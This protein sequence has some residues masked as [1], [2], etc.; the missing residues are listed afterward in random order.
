MPMLLM[1][2]I[3][4]M[5]CTNAPCLSTSTFFK[6][7]KDM[8]GSFVDDCLHIHVFDIRRTSSK[9][10]QIAYGTNKFSCKILQLCYRVACGTTLDGHWTPINIYFF[11]MWNKPKMNYLQWFNCLCDKIYASSVT[12]YISFGLPAQIFLLRLMGFWPM[13]NCY[14]GRRLSSESAG[15]TH[16][17]YASQLIDRNKK[18]KRAMRILVERSMRPMIIDAGGLFELS[19]PAFVKVIFDRN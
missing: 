11:C 14:F 9:A 6:S 3:G 5:H 17:I 1:Y 16:A 19:W 10:P 13:V 12:E 8:K 15:I 2:S 4:G 7:N 18:C